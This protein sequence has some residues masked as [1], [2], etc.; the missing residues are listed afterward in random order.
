MK[1]GPARLIA[2][3]RAAL[4][5]AAGDVRTQWETPR[6][7]RPGPAVRIIFTREP[8]GDES[9]VEG[10]G[11]AEGKLLWPAR[12]VL[13]CASVFRPERER[14]RLLCRFAAS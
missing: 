3:R 8:V 7:H 10:P 11:A 2:L 5:C 4:R 13:L 12:K 14:T 1:G 6:T 9:R